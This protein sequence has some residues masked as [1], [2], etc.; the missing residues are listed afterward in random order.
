MII[1]TITLMLKAITEKNTG[2]RLGCELCSLPRREQNKATT[3]EHTEIIVAGRG[4][5]KTLIRATIMKM[6]G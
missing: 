2:D 3:A 6:T 4:A 5:M 1:T